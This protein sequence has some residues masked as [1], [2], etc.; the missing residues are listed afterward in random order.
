MSAFT[1]AGNKA[2]FFVEL[3]TKRTSTPSN[4][5]VTIASGQEPNKP[6][7]ND[8][9]R[10]M[11]RNM[12]SGKNKVSKTKWYFECAPTVRDVDEFYSFIKRH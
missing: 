10:H 8:H 9:M 2:V 3:L 5:T 4:P 11:T 6:T 1:S 7:Q 12:K